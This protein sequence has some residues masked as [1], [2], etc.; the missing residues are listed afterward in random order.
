MSNDKQITGNIGIFHAASELSRSGWNVMLTVRNA[1][2]ADLFAISADERVMH[3]IQV[4]AHANKPQDTHLGLE[5]ESYTTPWWVFIA[6]A[7]SPEPVC[8][9]ISLGEIR[10]RMGRDPGVRSGKPEHQR[11]FWLHR[12]Y[13]TPGSDFEMIEARNAW[14]RLGQPR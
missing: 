6:F 1:K 14:H 8:Y 11:L 2:G 12:R 13:Y 4:K 3:P 10:D 9:V 7:L 5:P